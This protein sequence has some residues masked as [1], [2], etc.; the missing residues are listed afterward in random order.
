MTHQTDRLLAAYRRSGLAF[1]GMSFERAMAIKP[2]SI[3]LRCAVKAEQ[4]SEKSAAAQGV[5]L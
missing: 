3:A 4:R 5:L 1:L 2:I